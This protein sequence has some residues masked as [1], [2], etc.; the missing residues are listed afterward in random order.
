MKK[1]I[2]LIFISSFFFISCSDE[3]VEIEKVIEL[4]RASLN[5]EDTSVKD[6]KVKGA[7]HSGDFAFR[8]DSVNQYS[9]G[10][11]EYLNDSLVNSRIRVCVNFWAR[12]NNPMKGDC[13]ALSLCK[14]DGSCTWNTFDVINYNA[15]PNEWVNIVDSV[16]LTEE[17]FNDTG[18]LIKLFA[19]NANKSTVV[20]FD[21]ITIQIKKVYTVLE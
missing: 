15:K 11:V 3:Q 19:F 6:P 7:G 1:L 8:I 4:K 17:Q 16:T 9:A 14:K 12:A 20:D 18:S 13:Y 10:F 5:A 2:V 21:D